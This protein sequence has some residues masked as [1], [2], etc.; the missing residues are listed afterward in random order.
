MI[1]C[2]TSLPNYILIN[3]SCIYV[4]WG[5]NDQI[6]LPEGHVSNFASASWPIITKY[7]FVEAKRIIFI[8][9]QTDRNF[10]STNLGNLANND[11]ITPKRLY[12]LIVFQGKE[13]TE[14]P[15]TG[16]WIPLRPMSLGLLSSL[17]I[18]I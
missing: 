1:F 6:C 15:R 18:H 4:N 13:G 16:S 17:I 14:I 10:W 5:N 7:D 8:N 9:V 11:Q 2:K 12:L 3:F